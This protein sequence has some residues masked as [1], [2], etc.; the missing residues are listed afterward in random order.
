MYPSLEN[1]LRKLSDECET[2]NKVLL[3]QAKKKNSRL[4]NTM[5]IYIYI[6][7]YI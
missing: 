7:M 2:K 5:Y 6:Y 3:V 1:E 4:E